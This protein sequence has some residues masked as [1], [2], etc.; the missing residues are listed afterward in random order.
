M[1]HTAAKRTQR[2]EARISPDALSLVRRAAEIEGR[3]ISDFVVAAAQEVAE[4]T[5][6]R[7]QLIQLALADFERMMEILSKPPK[8]TPG[9]KRA[10]KAHRSLIAS[11][12]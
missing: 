3:S 6:E 9:W 5:V 8:V 7:R 12:R 4:R 1:A 10:V 2:I 11:S